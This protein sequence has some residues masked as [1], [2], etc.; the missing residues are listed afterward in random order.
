MLDGSHK[1]IT[2]LCNN[3]TFASQDDAKNHG[4]ITA[5]HINNHFLI[6]G[7]HTALFALW[8]ASPG[9]S[10]FSKWTGSIDWWGLQAKSVASNVDRHRDVRS[11]QGCDRTVIL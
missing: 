5:L 3:V 11:W 10:C 4:D 2:A 7:L 8:N 6:A 9:V 1:Q